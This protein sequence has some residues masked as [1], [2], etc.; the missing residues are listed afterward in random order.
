MKKLGGHLGTTV[1]M[2]NNAYREFKKIDKDVVKLSGGKG[3][4][5]TIQIDKPRQDE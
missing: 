5:E 2:Y 1:N 3:S 4:V